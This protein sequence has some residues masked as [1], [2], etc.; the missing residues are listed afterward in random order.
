MGIFPDYL[1]Y[2][3]RHVQVLGF[4]PPPSR[5]TMLHI[6][7]KQRD[8]KIFFMVQDNLQVGRRYHEPRRLGRTPRSYPKTVFRGKT[9]RN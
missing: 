7:G 5:A 8:L 6:F 4:S 9:V 3:T 1:E 2:K